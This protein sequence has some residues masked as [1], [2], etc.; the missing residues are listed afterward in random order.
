MKEFNLFE[1]FDKLKIESLPSTIY[2]YRCWKNEFHKTI[3]TK[4][5]LYFAHP[6]D[7][8][9]PY[10]VRP[11][12]NYIVGKIHEELA[13]SKI[14][15]AG[16]FIDSH[17]SKDQLESVVEQKL[18]DL[19]NDPIKYF[20]KN[21]ME[22]NLDRTRYDRFGVLSFCSSFKNENM[23]AHYGNNHEGFAI[24][25]NRHYLEKEINCFVK[26]VEYSEKP[27][28]YRIMGDNSG[29]FFRELFTKSTKWEHEQEVRFI[30]LGIGQ[31]RNRVF[32]FDPESVKEIIF[33]LKTP[34]E[35]QK[36]IIELAQQTI[37]NVPFYKLKLQSESFG[38]EKEKVL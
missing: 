4:R 22:Y 1:E 13:R 25:F 21:R 19:L 3:I 35:T 9:D 14:K 17:L 11:P 20:R 29:L 8:N 16:K 33:G 38:F 30:T 26:K 34:E 27:L 5:E 23:W 28:A 6:H 37:P 32:E 15:E 2:K 10:D 24:G 31:F 18:K 12:H 7:L 36:E